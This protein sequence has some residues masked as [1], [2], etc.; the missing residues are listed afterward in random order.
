MMATCDAT[1]GGSN[2]RR[3]IHSD[4]WKGVVCMNPGIVTAITRKDIVD[5]IRNRYLLT[6]LIT[7]LF[8]ALL[9][10]VLLPGANP[11]NLL[12]VVVHDSGS[13]ALVLELQKTPQINVVAVGSK[14]ATAGEVE[15]RDAIGGL[16]I[17]ANFDV[18]VAA[19]KQPELT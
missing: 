3:S 8:V 6:A 14:D 4:G 10:R 5:A 19:G 12:T 15:K 9:F 1:L 2:S 7:P 16:A 13:S 18:D 17:P 11:R